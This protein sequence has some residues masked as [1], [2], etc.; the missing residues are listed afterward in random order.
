MMERG[1]STSMVVINSYPAPTSIYFGNP[2]YILTFSY[3]IV[4]RHFV[5][6]GLSDCVVLVSG[7]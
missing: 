6:S 5:S 1:W 4:T 7:I 2:I 3:G